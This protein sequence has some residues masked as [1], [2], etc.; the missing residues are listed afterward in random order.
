MRGFVWV[1]LAVVAAGIAGY[2]LHDEVGKHLANPSPESRPASAA[3]RLVAIAAGQRRRAGRTL[4]G[5]RRQRR[6]TGAS[7]DG[8]GRRRRLAGSAADRRLDRSPRKRNLTAP[9]AVPSPRSRHARQ[10]RQGRR[11]D[12]E[13]RPARRM[14]PSPRTRPY[15]SATKRRST[16]KRKYRN[17][18]V[19]GAEGGR[20]PATA[21]QAQT[22][23]AVAAA[24][25]AVDDAS[26][27]PINCARQ[28]RDQGAVRR[29]HRRVSGRGGQPRPA[30]EPSGDADPDGPGRRAVRSL[31][32]RPGAV[33]RRHRQRH[34]QAH[35][36][37]ARQR[38]GA[39][40]PSAS[41]TPPWI[42]APAPCKR[43][44]RWPTATA[45]LARRSVDSLNL[46]SKA[47]VV[48]VPTWPSSRRPPGR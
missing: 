40:A 26:W 16:G 45:A 34:R 14:P 7:V 28:H 11:C 24:T 21:D 3:G 35:R 30:L 19:A 29:P 36:H 22:A 17:G 9:S 25:I 31:R 4:P 43:G 47:G 10:R 41:S 37:P 44:A 1:A 42:A 46:G 33:A 38:Q 6:A 32:R 20:H 13:T 2:E 23:E 5:W 48:L 15:C 27:Q 39:A 18:H 8:G 12:A